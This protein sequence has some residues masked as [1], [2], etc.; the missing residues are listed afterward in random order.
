MQEWSGETQQVITL[1]KPLKLL[2]MR[3]VYARLNSADILVRQALLER[4]S[5][6]TAGAM[7]VN[8]A[9]ELKPLPCVGGRVWLGDVRGQ[10]NKSI[11]PPIE[12]NRG[13]KLLRCNVRTLKHEVGANILKR[14]SVKEA[15]H[16][17]PFCHRIELVLLLWAELSRIKRRGVAWCVE[18]D[19]GN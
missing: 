15:L 13:D 16:L 4:S 1:I 9:A 6:G 19:G 2:T 14:V 18:S 17:R 3:E 10:I 12:V 7:N 11:V 5:D 8:R